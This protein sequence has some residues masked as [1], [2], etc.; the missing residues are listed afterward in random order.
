[1]KKIISD[2]FQDLRASDEDLQRDAASD[3]TLL[4]ERALVP[5]LYKANTNLLEGSGLV[6]VQLSKEE[7]EEIVQKMCEYIVS[8]DVS[9]D[10]QVCFTGVVGER[11]NLE[12]LRSILH[13]LKARYNSL[14]NGRTYSVLATTNPQY[15]LDESAECLEAVKSMIK[16]YSLVEILRDLRKRNDE[17]LDQQIDRL[18]MV[19]SHLFNNDERKE[20]QDNYL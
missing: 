16:E 13:F 11:L 12:C 8:D 15:F 7:A 10:V 5:G 17:D 6:D 20:E 3:I 9:L 18:E 1:M 19:L 4:V 14:D 2:M